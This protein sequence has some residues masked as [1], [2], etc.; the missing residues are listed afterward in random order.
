MVASLLVEVVFVGE[1]DILEFE[2]W[3]GRVS[4]FGFFFFVEGLR[5]GLGNRAE[6]N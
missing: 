6:F 5:I 3:G 4:G 1:R 2:F